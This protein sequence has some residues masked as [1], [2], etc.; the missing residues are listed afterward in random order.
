MFTDNIKMH[1]FNLI[2]VYKTQQLASVE[3]PVTE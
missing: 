1:F 3:Y 2:Q